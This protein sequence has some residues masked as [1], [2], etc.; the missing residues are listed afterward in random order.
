MKKLR[1]LL[2]KARSDTWDLVFFPAMPL[3]LEMVLS[4]FPACFPQPWR[5]HNTTRPVL[6]EPSVKHILQTQRCYPSSSAIILI[7]WQTTSAFLLP[8]L[9]G[10][11]LLAKIY[12]AMKVLFSLACSDSI[13]D[14]YVMDKSFRDATSRRVGSA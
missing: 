5:R 13:L 6:E 8:P 2:V 9:E 4:I 11:I 1:F 3:T 10:K 12:K 7:Y 14:F